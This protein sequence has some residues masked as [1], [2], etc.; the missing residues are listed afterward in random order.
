[1]TVTISDTMT[2]RERWCAA[3]DLKPVDRLPFWPKLNRAYPPMQRPPFSEMEVREIHAWIGSDPIEHL[4]PGLRRVYDAGYGFA[5]DVEDGVRRD[6]YTTPGGALTRVN[7]FDNDSKSWH[8]IAFPVKTAEDIDRM[9]DW[10]A[11]V[12]VELD[13]QALHRA[14]SRV[15]E[16]GQD[17]VT[18]VSVR[19]SGLMHWVE[20][21]AGIEAA[22]LLLADEPQRVRVLFAQVHRVLR[23]E[24]TL[25]AEH[26]PADFIWLTENTSTTLVSVEQY[27][28]LN[29]EH[30]DEYAR[31]VHDAGGRLILH[32]C[33]HLKRLLPQL[34][35]MPTAGFEAFTAPTLGDTTLF[36]GRTACPDKCLIGGTHA[37]LWLEPADA[38][39]AQLKSWLDELPHHRGLVLTSSGVMPPICEP[40]RIKT[41]RDRVTRYPLRC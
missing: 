9:A 32:M 33:G 40:Q 8:P 12:R 34:A 35:G 17:A 5:S 18:A 22:H 1:M 27:R 6:V 19:Q 10:F 24:I 28:T 25:L 13:D 4:P 2:S 39:I 21:L 31:I 7:T 14:R 26:H 23:E 3:L 29:A 38:I 15:R 20:W 30:I 36:D 16:V 37:M 41:V 11:H